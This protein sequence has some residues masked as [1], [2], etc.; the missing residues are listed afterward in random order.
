M[1]FEQDS[2]SEISEETWF[3]RLKESIK[4]VG[5]GLLLF[6]AAFPLLF[7]NEGRA[8]RRAKTLDEGAGAVVSVKAAAVTPATE[9]KLIHAS[10]LAATDGALADPSL[11]VSTNSPAL[12]L[13]RRVEM[14]QWRQEKHVTKKKRGGRTVKITRY[15]Y[16]QVWSD[17]LID[18]RRF[19]HHVTHQNPDHMTLTSHTYTAPRVKVGALTLPPALVA[20]VSGSEPLP[21]T[22]RMRWHIKDRMLRLHTRVYKGS[23]YVGFNPNKP[24][25]GDMR[26][27]FSVVRP[28]KVSL[29]GKQLAGA[30]VGPYRT[31]GGGTIYL[32]TAGVVG[33]QAMFKQAHA[34]NNTLSWI[35]RG[36]GFALL[37]FGL[38]LVF[39]PLSTIAD[40]VPLLGDLLRFGTLLFAAVMSV[41]LAGGTI[42]IAWIAHRPLLGIPVLVVGLG[43]VVGL[44]LLGARRK[45]ARRAAAGSQSHPG[46]PALS[47]R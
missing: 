47:A 11:G 45:N 34:A 5:V 32:L 17:K 19:K 8:V 7:W 21:V 13:V 24:R 16:K 31:S 10:G 22:Q 23:Y 43:A 1:S 33:P 28:Q 35:L 37:F 42:A 44:K 3:D 14:L 25:V 2:Y 40:A 4:S 20:R 46:T 26:V 6:V 39:S 36:V 12:K 15:D 18:S 9:G 30:T 41:V 27:R 29:V 38:L